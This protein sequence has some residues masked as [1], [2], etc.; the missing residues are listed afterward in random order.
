MLAEDRATEEK[1]KAEG[2]LKRLK[3]QTFLEAIKQTAEDMGLTRRN[4]G[5]TRCGRGR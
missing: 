4:L 2:V 5:H 3:Y 1:R